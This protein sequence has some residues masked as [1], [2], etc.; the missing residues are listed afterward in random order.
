[1]IFQAF[2]KNK[3]LKPSSPGALLLSITKIMFQTSCLE[4]GQSKAAKFYFRIFCCLCFCRL[5]CSIFPQLHFSCENLAFLQ[6]SLLQSYP[7]VATKRVVLV[8][9]EIPLWVHLEIIGLLF[10]VM[11]ELNED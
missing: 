11:A 6:E 5:K 9:V 2:L 8:I 10:P 1:M 7:L 3:T 4:V